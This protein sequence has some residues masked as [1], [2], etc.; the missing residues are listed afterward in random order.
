M[1]MTSLTLWASKDDMQWYP[2]QVASCTALVDFPCLLQP[3]WVWRDGQPLPRPDHIL[4]LSSF[5]TE[6]SGL[7]ICPLDALHVLRAVNSPDLRSGLAV[8]HGIQDLIRRLPVVRI[9]LSPGLWAQRSR[10]SPEGPADGSSQM[11]HH[12]STCTFW[13]GFTSEAHSFHGVETV[14]GQ[15]WLWGPHG[16]LWKLLALAVSLWFLYFYFFK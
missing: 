11:T 12:D 4:Q 6:V 10:S 7:E 2:E 16:S 5:C 1:A 9:C 13:F 3:L 14:R 15:K 8:I